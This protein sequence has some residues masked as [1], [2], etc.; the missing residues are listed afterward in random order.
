MIIVNLKGGIGN[1]LFQYAF[2]RHLSILFKKDLFLNKTEYIFDRYRAFGLPAFKLPSNCYAGNFDDLMNYDQVGEETL[3]IEE[4]FFHFDQELMAE[5]KLHA[6][7]DSFKGDVALLISGYWQSE[8][9]F[10]AIRDVIRM[11]LHFQHLPVGAAL[12]LQHTIKSANSVMIHIRRGDYLKY[13]DFFSVVSTEY[14][15]GAIAYC[16]QRLEA[17]VFYV[18]SDDIPWCKHHLQEIKDLTFI[19]ETF[20]DEHSQSYLQLMCSCKHFIISA[21]TYSWWASWLSDHK[22]K[23]V[24]APKQWY[25]DTS[26]NT[27]DIYGREWVRL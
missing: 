5:L 13:P 23:L 25:T 20:H 17:P 24:I 6:A 26:K 22:E 4:R 18:F 19:G 9:Y 7:E 11:D 10:E 21:S 16:R 2:G 15:T 14:I 27:H 1:Q 12:S 8:K 3:H